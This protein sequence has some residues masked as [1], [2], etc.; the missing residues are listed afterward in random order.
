M[1]YRPVMCD[2]RF[3][4]R[5]EWLEIYSRVVLR[6]FSCFHRIR[7]RFRRADTGRDCVRT[8]ERGWIEGLFDSGHPESVTAEVMGRAC[9]TSDRL[10]TRASRISNGPE[11]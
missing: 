4:I 11:R 5:I 8:S 3:K 2:A 10:L 1:I 7:R 9:A 6:G